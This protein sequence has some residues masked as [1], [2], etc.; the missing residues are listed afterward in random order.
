M[1][2]DR[3]EDWWWLHEG[4]TISSHPNLAKEFME[5]T[6]QKILFYRPFTFLEHFNEYQSQKV[7][8]EVIEEVKNYVVDTPPTN[9]SH[10][11]ELKVKGTLNDA[12]DFRRFC[13]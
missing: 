8:P 10:R 9:L 11:F 3:K 13:K 2:D 12:K 1:L 5:I 7:A 6:S 4:K